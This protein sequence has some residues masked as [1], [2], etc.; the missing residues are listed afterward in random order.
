M[1]FQVGEAVTSTQLK[2]SPKQKI[3]TKSQLP[4]S[5]S[6]AYKKIIEIEAPKAPVPEKPEFDYGAPKFLTQLQ[7]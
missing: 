4:D 6:G 1:K 2:C 3:I 7:V 5:M